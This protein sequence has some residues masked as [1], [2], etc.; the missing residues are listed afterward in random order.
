MNIPGLEW[1]SDW[2]LVYTGFDPSGEGARESLCS[3]G[4]GYFTTRGAAPWAKADGVRYPGVYLAGGY[5]RLRTDIAGRT[6]ENEDLVNLPN[7]VE[8]RLAIGGSTWFDERAV[9]LLAYRQE[10]DLQR[11]VLLRAMTF[12]DEDGRRSTLHE[13][14]LVSMADMHL[15]AL[16]LTL[17]AENWSGT[18]TLQSGIDGQVANA[19]AKLYARFNNRHLEPV[20]SETIGD[21]AVLLVT[22]TNTSNLVVAEAAR[23]RVIAGDAALAI[24]RRSLVEPGYAGQVLEVPVRAGAPLRIEKLAVLYTSRDA[25]ISD[26]VDAARK[27]I[28][29]A[30]AFDDAFAAHALSWKQFWARFDIR[31]QANESGFA[32]NVPMLLRLNLFHLLQTASLNSIGLDIGVPARAWTGEA[33]EG[34]IFWDELFIL[35]TLT[36]RLP[37]ITRSLLM[38]RYR[39]LGEAK[40]AARREG[41]R[42]AM[43]PWQSGSDGQEETQELN[44]NP[45]SQRWVPDNSFRQRHVGSA[46]AWTVWHYLQVTDDREFLQFY[47][48]EL[49]LE[50]ARFWASLATYDA[51]R[52]RYEIHGVMGPDEFHEGYADAPEP[53][54]RNNAYTNVMA[55]WVLWRALEVLDLLPATRREELATRLGLSSDEIARWDDIS[56]RM[57]VPFHTDGLI[58][59]F[60]GFEDLAELDWEAYRARYGNIQRIEL[61]LEA[62]GDSANRYKLGKQA[63][64][65]MLFYLFSA[66][67]LCSLFERLGYGFDPETIP[68]NVAYYDSRCSH[69]SSLSRVVSSWVLA[70]SDRS[71]ASEYLT[72]ALLSDIGDIQGGTAAEGVH[73]GAMAG[74]VDL[75]QR[76]CTGVEVT[77]GVLRFKP[78]LPQSAKALEMCIRYRGHWLDLSLVHDVLSVRSRESE[79]A[80]IRICVDGL[81]HAL[82]AG[83]TRTFFCSRALDLR[84]AA[85]VQSA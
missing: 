26:P 35:P 78:C 5:N 12:E 11:G 2:S 7:W 15:A 52:A 65:L 33:Y 46:I 16:E 25:A 34:H 58:S 76:V 68:D 30:P 17:T 56:R 40:A 3:L 63:D 83:E 85:P 13:R 51:G 79:A 31:L 61:I 59:Q 19:G 24:E 32:Q 18:L 20:A 81:E 72:E 28:A 45:R 4:N 21:D 10:L 69:G 75:V 14:R 41:L 8:L 37:E 66:E 39:R 29:N 77:G 70:R 22:R 80:P 73:L 60:E 84:A 23:T 62:E 36:F 48:A 44:L 9:Q 47:A 6:V 71:K 1:G 55:V 43:F 67:E 82:G 53:G 50:I 74:S 42:G 64:V 49:I 57:F 38:Y 27:A 54:L